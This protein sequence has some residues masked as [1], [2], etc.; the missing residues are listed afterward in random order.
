[1]TIDARFDVAMLTVGVTLDGSG[2]GSVASSPASLLCPGTCSASIAYGTELELTA[3]P[4]AASTFL[5]WSGACSG[6]DG[7]RFT[8]TA[9]TTVTATFAAA[10]ELVVSRTGTGTG[11][12]QSAPGGISCGAACTKQF[13]FGTL[14]TLTAAADSTSSF[15]G[16]SGACSGTGSCQVTMAGAVAVNAAFALK[17]FPL[18]VA[19]AGTGTGVVTSAPAG[20]TCGADCT[21]LYDLGTAV[22]LTAMPSSGSTFVGWSGA[23]TGTGTCQVTI[24]NATSVTATFTTFSALLAVASYSGHS[25]SIFPN[26]AS[27]NVAPIRTISGA[28]TSLI[29]PRGVAV[30]GNEIIAADQGA[31]AVVVFD[32]NAD[33]NVAP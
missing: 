23:C 18:T 11:T 24:A 1:M 14:V 29:N 33:G 28:A 10:Q 2:G 22:T 3:A 32:L 15:T 5:G 31:T 27:G 13:P 26:N 21:E 19:R 8:V 30:V 9:D 4:A 17:Q 6:V 7:C 12:V 20:I 25:I 16:W